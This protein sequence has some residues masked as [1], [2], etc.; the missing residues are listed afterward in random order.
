M[1]DACGKLE[2]VERT[3]SVIDRLNFFRTT[4]YT[5]C[6][7]NVE[8]PLM[9]KVK[10]TVSFGLS[11]HWSEQRQDFDFKVENIDVEL[12]KVRYVNSSVD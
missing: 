7:V 12:Q 1:D 2:S 10:S 3:I 4:A 5:V 11:N 6:G 8:V 9:S